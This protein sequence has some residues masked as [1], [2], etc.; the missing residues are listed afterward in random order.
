MP[1]ASQSELNRQKGI[2][3]VRVCQAMEVFGLAWRG[4]GDFL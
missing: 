4:K 2:L 1:I 3:V